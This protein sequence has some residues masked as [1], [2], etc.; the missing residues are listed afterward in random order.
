MT[1][2]VMDK[3]NEYIGESV[4][5]T[6][7]FTASVAD[8]VEDGLTAAKRAARKGQEAMDDFVGDTSKRVKRSPIQSVLISLAV[9]V[10][11]GFL[12]GRTTKSS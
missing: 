3:T 7:E 5:K 8:A 11:F 12:V 9:G 10:A 4:R 6:S 1:K 2:S